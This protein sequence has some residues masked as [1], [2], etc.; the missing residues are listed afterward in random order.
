MINNIEIHKLFPHPKNPRTDLGDLTE[1]AESIKATG[2]LQNLTV[3]PITIGAPPASPEP[4]GQYTVVIGHRRLAAAKL[5]GLTELPCAV[6]EMTQEQQISTMLLENMQ[7][8]DLTIYE[9]AQGFQML[10]DFGESVNDIAEKTGFS[11][12]TVR[13][14]VKLLDLD[15]DQDKFKASVSRG[16][17]L[18]DYV[19]LEKI[20]DTDL[21]NKVLED[22]G[23]PKFNYSLKRAIS[24]EANDEN[25]MLLCQNLK[26]F[27]SRV[28]QVEPNMKYVKIYYA[29]QVDHFEKPDTAYSREY[30]YTES[31]NCAFLYT[32]Y[33]E[34]ELRESE[35]ARK[36][37]EKEDA[38]RATIEEESLRAYNLRWEYINEYSNA[39]AKKNKNII[40]EYLL[41]TMLDVS[42]YKIYTPT[43]DELYQILDIEFPDDRG[44][45]EW[46]YNDIAAKVT[47]EP[48]RCLLAAVYLRLDSEEKAY[49]NHWGEVKYQENE[50]LDMCYEMLERLGYEISEQEQ[51]FRDGTHELYQA[52]ENEASDVE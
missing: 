30:F 21:R 9:Q 50:Q 11:Q 36:T 46:N 19:A 16:A 4:T 27:A 6:V 20:K 18:M 49:C 1:L 25:M 31:D 12:T 42:Q 43:Y 28:E 44:G 22:I 17:T 33:T 26:S 37:R 32:A 8:S 38:A 29:S 34:E 52:R 51:Q 15:L 41:R 2:I 47:K 45:E 5:A 10:L 13:R 24:L 14:R 3:V 40:A 7:R 39:K 23:T 48:E 35:S